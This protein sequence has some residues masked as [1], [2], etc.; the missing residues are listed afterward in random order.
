MDIDESII[1]MVLCIVGVIL[2]GIG[3][4]LLLSLKYGRMETQRVIVINLSV[5]DCCLSAILTVELSLKFCKICPQK[6][7]QVLNV[8]KYIINIAFYY[9]TFWLILDRYLHI[10]LNIKYQL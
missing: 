7:I 1:Y 8:C 5:F 10:K 4:Y 3:L 2:N 6:D 9:T